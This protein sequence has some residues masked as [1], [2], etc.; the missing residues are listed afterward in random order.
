[1]PEA[2]GRDCYT[3]I[4]KS[5]K[6]LT[7]CDEIESGFFRDK[8]YREVAIARKDPAICDNI[9]NGYWRATCHERVL[10]WTQP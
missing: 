4:A 1:M 3:E 8:C 7:I 10:N 6:K 9:E 5:E 2:V